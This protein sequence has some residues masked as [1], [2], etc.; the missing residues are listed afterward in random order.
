MDLISVLGITIA[1]DAARFS[2][3]EALLNRWADWDAP[4]PCSMSFDAYVAEQAKEGEA[5][6][7]NASFMD[8]D[9]L[10][11]FQAGLRALKK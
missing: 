1:V 11:G 2:N 10:K 7:V 5:I 9:A 3:V 4:Y 6:I 8:E